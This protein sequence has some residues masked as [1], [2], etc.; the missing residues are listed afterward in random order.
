MKFIF[1]ISSI[2]SFLSIPYIQY[3]KNV[4]GIWEIVS[5]D[6]DTLFFEKRLEWEDDTSKIEFYSD[7]KFKRSFLYKNCGPGVVYSW[8]YINGS[9]SISNDSI[10]T[11]DENMGFKSIMKIESI[12]PSTIQIIHS[13]IVID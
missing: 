6:K 2:I 9:Y 7:K 8:E 3:E 1:I 5:L 12:T 4:L 10:I 11:L 13:E